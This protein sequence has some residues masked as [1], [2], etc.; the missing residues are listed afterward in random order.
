MRKFWLRF[1]KCLFLVLIFG[2][3]IWLGYFLISKTELGKNINSV[4]NLRD[5]ISKQG[6]WSYAVFWLMQ[7]LQVTFL[8]IPSMISTLA[9]V[10]IF[11]PF[12][13]FI[14]SYL[15]ITLG[16]LVAFLIGKKLGGKII[17][18]VAG[19]MTYIKLQERIRQGKFLYFLMMLFPFFPDD[20]LCLVAGANKMDTKFFVFTIL[21]TKLIGLA[22][23]CFLGNSFIFSF[24]SPFW[25]FFFVLFFICVVLCFAYK[26]KI[27]KLFFKSVANDENNKKINKKT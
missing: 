6:T 13:T 11:G 9:G 23:I 2:V 5:Y 4:E 10:L 20:L 16:S 12:I 7:F 18:W 25:I 19:E 17:V 21:I 3:F 1:F 15:A 26:N 14:L 8:P 24:K 22:S 27:E